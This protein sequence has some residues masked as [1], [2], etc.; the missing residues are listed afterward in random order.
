MKW[1]CGGVRG[2]RPELFGASWAAD[3]VFPTHLSVADQA[4]GAELRYELSS[5]E[6]TSRHLV[7]RFHGN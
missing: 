3:E 2:R 7:N 1:T 5:A 4:R 6:A